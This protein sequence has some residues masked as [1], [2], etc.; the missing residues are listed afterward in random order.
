MSATGFVDGSGN[1]LITIFHPIGAAT[2]IANVGY[3]SSLN[4]DKDLSSIFLG[5]TS[6]TKAYLTGFMYNELDLSELFQKL[7]PMG[8]ITT[9]Q[10]VQVT[11]IGVEYLYSF[12]TTTTYTATWPFGNYIVRYL[13]VAGGGGGGRSIGAGGG[14]GG[15]L[16]NTVSFSLSVQTAMT[17]TVGVGGTGM[18]EKDGPVAL[19]GGNS[20]ITSTMLTVTSI[21]GGGGSGQSFNF[22]NQ[23]QPGMTGGSGAGESR[24]GSEPGT[25]TSGQGNSGGSYLT[26]ERT[27][28]NAGGGGGAGG[29]G[30]NGNN[31]E[32]Y[33]FGGDGI[34]NDITGTAT[35]YGGGG[36][37]G[38]LNFITSTSG[39]T[40]GNGGGGRGGHYN[41]SNAT[42][43][44]PTS[45][46]ANTG[47]G[48]GGDAPDFN[49]GGDGGSGIVILRIRNGAYITFPDTY[50]TFVKSPT[51]TTDTYLTT[52]RTLTVSGETTYKNGVYTVSSSSAFASWSHPYIAF[53]NI[54]PDNDAANWATGGTSVT[55]PNNQRTLT[56]TGYMIYSGGSYNTAD[57]IY[58]GTTNAFF[59]TTYLFNG[60]STSM[61]GEWI[62]ISFPYFIELTSITLYKYPG[63]P[64][65]ARMPYT[66]VILGSIDGITWNFIHNFSSGALVG[67]GPWTYNI[68]TTKSYTFI[69]FVINATN[70]GPHLNIKQIF[71]TGIAIS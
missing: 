20:S 31:S 11:Q 59:T 15:V 48:G 58:Q 66:G 46:T 16:T 61:N 52:V 60:S 4:G 40:G 35:F 69:R 39:G 37:G 26:D 3:E 68:S 51:I 10:F 53:C 45:G 47:G 70:K 14:G 6:G 67:N 12:T 42:T 28:Y 1:D 56:N 27:Y 29:V 44:L 8:P 7:G 50:A 43:I 62:Q 41:F 33:G 64:Y 19:N 25:G 55:S 49:P 23:N 32:P 5:Y 71:Y 22:Y 65:F 38:A 34:S 13:C 63:E 9:N 30:Q 2:K 36:G 17:I 21:G 24:H 54:N 57:G 18:A